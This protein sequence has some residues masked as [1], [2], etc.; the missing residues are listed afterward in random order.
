MLEQVSTVHP[1]VLAAVTDHLATTVAPL[2]T[3]D[4]SN[5][6]AGRQRCWLEAEAPLAASRPWADGLHD[7]RLWDWLTRLCRRAGFTPD[8]GLVSLG[9]SIRRHRDAGYAN[10]LALS[11]NLGPALFHYEHLHPAFAWTPEAPE[12]GPVDEY[13]LVGGEVLRFNCK[14]PHSAQALAADRWAIQVWSVSGKERRRFEQWM[15][16]GCG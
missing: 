6:A 7:V 5:Y 1:D 13:E 3:A 2:L 12:A 14:N 8:V 4:V 11:V 16:Q 15:D 10:A 9:G